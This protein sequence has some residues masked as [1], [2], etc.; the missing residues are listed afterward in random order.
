MHTLAV[1]VA[2]ET[3]LLAPRALF[4]P[5]QSLLVVADVHFGKAA[6][7]RA[8][9]IPVPRGTTMENL[10]AMDRLITHHGPRE[11]LFLGDFLHHRT[12]RAR[13]TLDDL[14]KWRASHAELALTLVRG[15]HD[16]H[17][18]DPPT[19]L[20][21]A[22]VDE[23]HRI[24]PFAFAHHP[25]PQAD[26]YVFAGHVHPVYRLAAGGDALRLPCFLFGARVGLLPSFGAFTG[27]HP[28]RPK[29]GDRLFVTAEDAV[30]AVE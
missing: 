25:E 3:L 18:G 24:G 9:G 19:E 28:V 14:A 7:F 29:P 16:R 8:H 15:N 22:V 17:A 20:N 11:L 6:T 2:G 23:P 10:D 5:R 4:W 27:G 1:D 21:I 30:F 26:A 12:G 13:E